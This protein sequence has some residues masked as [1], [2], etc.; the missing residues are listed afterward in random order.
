MSEHDDLWKADLRDGIRSVEDLQRLPLTDEEHKE[1]DGAARQFKISIPAS[2]L[3]LINWEDADDPIR[4][5]AL[6]SDQEL[7]VHT[8][9]RED[10]IGDDTYSPVQRLTHRYPDRAVLFPTYICSTYCRH[11]FRKES[12]NDGRGGFSVKE[13]EP[14][15][16]YIA[17]HQELRE[18][19]LSGGDPLMLSDENLTCIRQRL[20]TITHLRLLR[21]HTRVPV[22]LPLRVTDGTIRALDGRFIVVI[23]THFNHPREITPDAIS[24]CSLFRKAGF[25]LL[26]QTVLLRGVNDDVEVMKELLC[27]LVYSVGAKPYYLHHC[28]LTRGLGHLRTTIDEGLQIMRGLRG[29]ISGLCVPHYML[30][31]PGGDGKIP[32]GPNYVRDRSESQWHFDT[33]DGRTRSYHEAATPKICVAKEPANSH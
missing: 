12:L 23:V 33:Y 22:T 2:Y 32:L 8:L 20:E 5:Q 29:H 26:N 9:E 11:C 17:K 15:F 21:L 7:V 10:P 28:D 31:L 3:N 30:D 27:E 24:A 25:M 16:D 18:I 14:A 4:R 6:P 13:M 19:I 1:M